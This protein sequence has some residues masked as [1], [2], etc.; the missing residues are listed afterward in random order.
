MLAPEFLPCRGGVGVYIAEIARHMP[1]DVNIHIVTPHRV[2]MESQSI[3]DE[4]ISNQSFPSNITVHFLGKAQDSFFYNLKFQLH[5]AAKVK[6]LIK[7]YDIDIIHSQSA[8]P[9]LFLSLKKIKVPIVTTIHTTI[10]SQK[11]AI[12]S[13]QQPF[14]QLDSS[15]QFTF[16]FSPALIAMENWYYSKDRHYITVSDWAK[17]KVTIEKGIEPERIEVIHNGIDAHFF[18]PYDRTLAQSYL[19]ELPPIHSPVILFLSRMIQSKGI[20]DLITAIPTIL[21]RNDATFIIAGPGKQIK[22][23]VPK[24]NIIQLGYIPHDITRFLYSCADIFTLPSLSENFPLSV[25]EAMASKN[26]VV[27][28]NVGGIPEMITHE[29]N[30]VLIPPHDPRSIEKAITRLLE[31]ENYRKELGE[32]AREAVIKKFQWDKAAKLTKEYY[33]GVIEDANSAS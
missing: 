32:N 21:K 16:L 20:H 7:E 15:E 27:A 30:G 33:I 6:S 5:C 14:F 2:R 1:P 8:M 19:P 3:A 29:K 28:S 10:A 17:Q 18:Q 11:G 22:Y 4:E 12:K 9:D 23:S 26:A 13:S 25:L 24:Q 31:D